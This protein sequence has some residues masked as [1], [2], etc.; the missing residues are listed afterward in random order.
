MTSATY[1]AADQRTE[2]ANSRFC[3]RGVLKGSPT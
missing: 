2:A 3:S 1:S